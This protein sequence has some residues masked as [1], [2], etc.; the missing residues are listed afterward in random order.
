[1]GAHTVGPQ[2]HFWSEYARQHGTP[3]SQ[4][5][6]RRSVEHRSQAP[7]LAHHL[8]TIA[9]RITSL[10]RRRDRDRKK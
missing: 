9:I 2:W 6:G 8:T 7:G 1:V 5:P 4:S 3:H 10:G